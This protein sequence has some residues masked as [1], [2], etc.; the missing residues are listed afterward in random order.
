MAAMKVLGSLIV[1]V[2]VVTCD[3]I[4]TK[5]DISRILNDFMRVSHQTV[6]SLL[7]RN[8]FIG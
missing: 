3:E 8:S 2:T 5:E 6:G 1:L 4:V 7:K